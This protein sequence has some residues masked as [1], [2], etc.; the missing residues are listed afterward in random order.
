V[1]LKSLRRTLGEIL[2]ET[3]EDLPD[4]TWLGAGKLAAEIDARGNH[5]A[6]IR[7]EVAGPGPG[8]RMVTVAD[9]ERT[10]A[11][12]IQR[13]RTKTGTIQLEEGDVTIPALGANAPMRGHVVTRDEEDTDL[14]PNTHLIRPNRGHIDPWFLAGF[15][16]APASVRGAAYGTNGGRIEVRRL[17]VPFLPLPEQQA[18][19]AAFRRLEDSEARIREIARVTADLTGLIRTGLRNRT[20][21]PG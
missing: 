12:I 3:A 9:L 7:A 21:L 10:R 13:A 11:V 2:R 14:P 4:A 19:G 17:T 5:A 15:L 6:G 8:W 18:Y 20:I 1:L 16:V